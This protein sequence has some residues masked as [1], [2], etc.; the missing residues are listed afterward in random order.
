[1]ELRMKQ[2]HVKRKFWMLQVKQKYPPYHHFFQHIKSWVEQMSLPT[3]CI[4]NHTYK[5]MVK[6]GWGLCKEATFLA[7]EFKDPTLKSVITNYVEEMKAKNWE[8]HAN[9]DN[10]N[11]NNISNPIIAKPRGRPTKTRIRSGGEQTTKKS[12]SR[13]RQPL[14]ESLISYNPVQEMH[15]NEGMYMVY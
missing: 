12:N 10:D 8:N 14:G 15:N 3:L 5:C 4:N 9:N 1:M 6:C 7:V 11:D 2:V 13:I